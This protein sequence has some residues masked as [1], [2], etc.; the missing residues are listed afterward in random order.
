LR[1]PTSTTWSP[2]GRR[3]RGIRAPLADPV[4]V[5]AI[6]NG[7]LTDRMFVR[8]LDAVRL[9]DAGRRALLAGYAHR[10]STG[11]RHPTFGYTVTWWSRTIEV[12]T[13]TLLGA[14]DGSNDRYIGMRTR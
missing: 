8:G 7:E 13:R 12:R 2:K 14:L 5:R 11:I 3:S 10:L 9:G 4:V 6:N 1:R